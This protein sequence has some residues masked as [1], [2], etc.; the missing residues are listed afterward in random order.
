MRDARGRTGT[1]HVTYELTLHDGRVLRT[2]I[3]HPV[4]RTV[5]GAAIWAHILRDQLDVTEDGFWT[6]VLDGTL[7]DRG[8][9]ETPKETLPA[10]LVFLLIHRAGL[11]EE[12]VAALTKEEAMARLQRYWTEET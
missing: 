1:H 6:C 4:D 7:P 11:A 8:A 9:P 2:R 3:S 10:D 5:Y 12:E